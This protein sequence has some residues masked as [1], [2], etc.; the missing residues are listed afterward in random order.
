MP[1]TPGYGNRFLRALCPPDLERLRPSLSPVT[2]GLG[3]VINEAGSDVDVLYFPDGAILSVITLMEDG[4]GVES[5]TLGRETGYGLINALGSRTAFNRV[6]CQ[7]PGAAYRMPAAA[8][9]DAAVSPALLNLISRHAQVQA[10][11]SE[12]SAACNAVHHVEARL[13]RWL[14]ISSDRALSDVLPLTQEF[15]GFMLGVQ[16]TTVTSAARNLQSAGLIR[17]SRGRL[18]LLDRVGLED[19]ACECYRAVQQRVDELIG[20]EA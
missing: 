7:V 14:L 11:M 4:R 2:C 13:C 5:C 16:R 19:G 8:L 6:I 10:A 17:Y 20:A 15:L 18:E 3:E 1:S 9:K 12:Q